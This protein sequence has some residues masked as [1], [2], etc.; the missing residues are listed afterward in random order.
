MNN[1]KNLAI[2]I[3]DSGMGG[4]S[5]LA[6]LIKLMP[7]ERYIYYGDSKNAPYGVKT[8]E[9]VRKL[10]IEICDLLIE[11]GVKAIIVACN[12][13]TSAAIEELREK[14]DIPI[15]GM[16]PALKPATTINRNGKIVVMATE[17]TL[18]EKKFSALMD[19]YGKERD[20]I[21]LPC[22]KLVELIEAGIIEGKDIEDSIKE[23]F[24]GINMNEITSIVLGCTH[25]IFLKDYIKNFVGDKVYIIDGNIGTAN[26]L[27]NILK[28]RDLIKSVKEREVLIDIYNS[29]ENQGMIDLSKKLLTFSLEK[30]KF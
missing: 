13:A 2:G 3:F 26:H 27:N 8:P 11:K 1:D 4:I 17:M 12:T 25:Y 16:E 9:E 19:R 6:Q 23:C 15:I 20:I 7:N 10:S 30:L 28:E 18:K 24:K 22:P 14:Y 29:K 5:V 21:K